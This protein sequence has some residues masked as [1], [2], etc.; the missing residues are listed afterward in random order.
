MPPC[1]ERMLEHLAAEP[2]G[3]FLPIIQIA[4]I[5]AAVLGMAFGRDAKPEHQICPRCGE[6]WAEKRIAK[7]DESMKVDYSKADWN[8]VENHAVG[9]VQEATKV[10][11]DTSLDDLVAPEIAR[12]GVRIL[13]GKLLAGNL[14]FSQAV[15]AT[16]FDM[17]S[18]PEAQKS[19]SAL[20]VA[21]TVIS[22]IVKLLG[23][24]RK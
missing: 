13:K 24:F 17:A 1:E 4:L 2:V 6:P 16:N 10:T 21:I 19:E 18:L 14:S 23:L 8:A 11:T 5:A 20:T 3:T 9:L 15:A 22:V 7:E 12:Q